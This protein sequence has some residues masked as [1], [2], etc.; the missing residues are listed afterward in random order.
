MSPIPRFTNND[1][2]PAVHILTPMPVATGEIS[3]N[4]ARTLLGSFRKGIEDLVQFAEVL[5]Q[6]RRE[7]FKTAGRPINSPKALGELNSTGKSPQNT[8]SEKGWET[9]VTTQLGIHPNTARNIIERAKYAQMLRMA[10][11]GQ[12]IRYTDSKKQL[13]TIQ[14]TDRMQEI[15]AGLIEQV[16]A[17]T[18]NAKRAWAGTV[19]EGSNDPAAGKAPTDHYRVILRAITS[20][21]NSAAHWAELTPDDRFALENEWAALR[22]HLPST[23]Q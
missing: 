21:R 22:S 4:R 10:A 20:L 3:W 5:Q 15:A 16:A 11:D 8:P 19:G 1:D 13:V 12:T 7:F 23:F 17:G 2:Q 18:I 9:E 14:P 6:L